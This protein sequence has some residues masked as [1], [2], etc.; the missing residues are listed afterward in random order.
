[1]VGE[2]MIKPLVNFRNNSISNGILVGNN[3][4]DG[5]SNTGTFGITTDFEFSLDN[6]NDSNNTT[7]IK[8][9]SKSSC[10]VKDNILCQLS[11]LEMEKFSSMVD[12]LLVLSVA[13]LWWE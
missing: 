6:N 3:E 7:N 9:N 11:Q 1:M 13:K 8:R 4:Q 10:S 5:S 12:Y 2:C